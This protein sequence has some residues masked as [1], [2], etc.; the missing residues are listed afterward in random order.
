MSCKSTIPALDCDQI[1]MAVASKIGK[2]RVG[3]GRIGVCPTD[4]TR[5]GRSPP[6]RSQICRYANARTLALAFWLGGNIQILRA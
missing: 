5:E 1:A 2:V 4:A 6:R 3:N